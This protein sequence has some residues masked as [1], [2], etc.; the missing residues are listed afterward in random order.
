MSA[1]SSHTVSAD[2]TVAASMVLIDKLANPT[3]LRLHAIDFQGFPVQLLSWCTTGC[4]TVPL[5]SACQ[6]YPYLPQAAL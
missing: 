3:N 4:R 6:L 1:G 5:V 2:Q